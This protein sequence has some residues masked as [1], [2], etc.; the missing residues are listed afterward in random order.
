MI[1]WNDVRDLNISSLAAVLMQAG[2]IW[3]RTVEWRAVMLRQHLVRVKEE[4]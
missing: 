1:R 4:R 3:A 2:G